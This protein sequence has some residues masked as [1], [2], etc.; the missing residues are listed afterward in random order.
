MYVETDE[1][2]I[3]HVYEGHK[4]LAKGRSYRQV[5]SLLRRGYAT[6]LWQHIMSQP[7]SYLS[8]EEREWIAQGCPDE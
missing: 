2:G 3:I 6:R 5:A 1:N 8:E 4:E 7:H